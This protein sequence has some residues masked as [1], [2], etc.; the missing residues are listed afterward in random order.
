MQLRGI[1]LQALAAVGGHGLQRGLRRGARRGRAGCREAIPRACE[2]LVVHQAPAPS[3][4]AADAG[5]GML[6]GPQVGIHLPGL[7]V[8]QLAEPLAP[9]AQGAEGEALVQDQQSTILLLECHQLRQRSAAPGALADRLDHDEGPAGLLLTVA[10]AC[11]TWRLQR[12]LDLLKVQV[13]HPG[14]LRFAQAEA[15]AEAQVHL[16]VHD[17]PVACLHQRRDHAGHRGDPGGVRDASLGAQEFRQRRLHIQ[18]RQGA[19]VEAP[20]PAGAEA[21]VIHSLL[22]GLAGSFQGFSTVAQRVHRPEVVA[23]RDL[24]RLRARLLQQRQKAPS[25]RCRRAQGLRAPD[26][27]HI[28]MP[29]QW[30]IA[31]PLSVGLV[32]RVPRLQLSLIGAQLEQHPQL[33]PDGRDLNRGLLELRHRVRGRDAE[34]D[35]LVQNGHSRIAHHHHG[36]APVQAPPGEGRQLPG[37]VQH[38]WDDWGIDVTQHLEALPCK[39]LPEVVG[40]LADGSQLPGA[41]VAALPAGDDSQ[42]LQGLGGAGG[43]HG[44]SEDAARRHTPKLSD[45]LLGGSHVATRAAE[46]L[47]ECAHHHIHL[48]R[49]HAQELRDAPA[50]GAHRSDGVGL[51]QVEVGA[52]LVLQADNF[53]EAAEVSL[54]GVDAFHHHKNLAPR[55]A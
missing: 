8:L 9:N 16:G 19:P 24:R 48:G 33:P 29:Q 22:C 7:H 26:W 14:H 42:R 32:L 6:K 45:D 10:L 51:I 41:R 53:T 35:A 25:R 27:L 4:E 15:R 50:A 37:V 36:D 20:G 23:L 38:H 39:L 52:I 55:L 34:S 43:G 31:E 1:L 11:L 54:H 47:G 44:P 49:G 17:H 28:G 3:A 21:V 12:G 40:I 5:Q 2:A 13:R 30:G 18:V 46:G